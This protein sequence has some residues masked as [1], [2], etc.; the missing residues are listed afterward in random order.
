M[1]DEI[2]KERRCVVVSTD[3]FQ[4]LGIRIVVPLTEYTARKHDRWPWAVKI[5]PDDMNGITKDVAAVADQ[6]RCVDLT[7]FTGRMGRLKADDLTSVEDAMAIAL[8]LS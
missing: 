4:N 6:M 8:K 1:G 2:Q 5:S 3:A 7:R